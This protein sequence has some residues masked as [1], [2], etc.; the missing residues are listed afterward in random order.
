MLIRASA[1]EVFRVIVD[2]ELTTRI[3]FTE[4]TGPLEPGAAVR[5]TWGMYGGAWAGVTVREF[6]Q[7]ERL[8][9]EWGGE[10]EEPT[11]VAW[12]LIPR[13][14]GTFL[15]VRETGYAGSSDD[16][17][18]RMLDSSGGFTL[19]LAAIKALLEHDVALR[20]VHDRH[21]DAWAPVPSRS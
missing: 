2:P 6:V 3:W 4:S 5:W 16:V 14:E 15:R 20:V 17:A 9:M 8:V 21:P 13:E 11:T 7:D 18:A 1:A 19:V 12:T 10:G